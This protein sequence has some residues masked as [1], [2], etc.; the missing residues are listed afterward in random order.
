[1]SELGKTKTACL[2]GLCHGG[3][4]KPERRPTPAELREKQGNLPLSIVL[5]ISDKIIDVWVELAYNMRKPWDSY[6]E[7][8]YGGTRTGVEA[9]SHGNPGDS[10]FLTY[11]RKK[12]FGKRGLV[13]QGCRFVMALTSAAQCK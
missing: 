6:N 4:G 2:P 7:R 12:G 10:S 11:C 1:M 5:R 3:N 9:E 8:W 13:S